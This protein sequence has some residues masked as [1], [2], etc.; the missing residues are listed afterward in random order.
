MKA[1]ATEETAMTGQQGDGR[2]DRRRLARWL[3]AALAVA[4][5]VAVL[6]AM[7]SATDYCVAPNTSCG[8]SN[9]ATFEQA[10]D[11]AD[12]ATDAD[13]VFLGAATYTSPTA[14]GYRYDKLD[15]PVE[16]IGQGDG[17]TVLTS[18]TGGNA[19]LWLFGGTGT[20][21]HDLTIRLPQ[22][23]FGGLSGLR[24]T[25]TARRIEVVEAPTQANP[26]NGVD[27][28][29]GGTL[30]DSNVTLG[31][32]QNTIAVLI[33]L[34]GG[35]VR[36]SVLSA[37]T[38]V[39]SNDGG[40]IE[41][42]RVTGSG[43]GVENVRN[44]MT[45]RSSLIRFTDGDGSAGIYADP[46][47]GSHPTIDADGVTVIGPNLPDTW[48]AEVNT[49]VYPA[50]SGDVNLTNSV[51]RGVSTPLGAFAAGSGQ[52][53]VAASYSDYDP[54]G[55]ST[56]GA[57]A[58]ITQADVANVGDA[59]FVDAPGGDFRL[60]PD[61]P[62]IDAGDPATS[63]GLDLDANPLVG[64]G[65]ADGIARRDMGAFEL[66]PA[67]GGGQQAV[68]GGQ[69]GGEAAADTEPPIVSAFRADP[70][71]FAVARASTT[72]AAGIARGTRFRYTLSEDSRVALTI[73]RALAGR[74]RG[75][76]CLR[77]TPQLRHAKRCTRYRT[78]GTLSRSAKQGANRTRFTGKI[79]TR[80]LRP[81]GY[82]ARLIATDAAANRSTP[83]AAR[84]R[85][86]GS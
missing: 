68:G 9:V 27:L 79:G 36:G 20:S 71:L 48:G 29:S 45:I 54:S 33:D 55:N 14:N 74:R 44:V 53:K 5:L 82:R 31:H 21:V 75:G 8:G 25:N 57:N 67:V 86:A 16:I 26:R 46:Q 15:S 10:L 11:L 6:P 78:I 19:V 23:A 41:R 37:R 40:T 34:G 47:L 50:E 24:T 60:R 51:I 83:H 85:I 1:S 61:S 59:R 42:S 73:Q 39:N 64:D 76:E 58:S 18:P 2:S 69:Q 38:G 65:N 12:N 35:A 84:F 32:V 72:I 52:A 70:S 77:P 17:Q 13:R 43:T 56:S 3:V 63:Q 81:G 49:F 62:L 30:E 80:A 7:A 28:E 4:L 66:P 22:N